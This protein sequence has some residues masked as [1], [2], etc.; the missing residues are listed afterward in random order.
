MDFYVKSGKTQL[1]PYSV[2]TLKERGYW[3]PE[4]LV[5]KENG[6]EWVRMADLTPADLCENVKKEVDASKNP[7]E[8]PESFTRAEFYVL[9]TIFP[10]L[11]IA[12]FCRKRAIDYYRGENYELF[13]K[14]EEKVHTCIVVAI[15]LICFLVVGLAFYSKTRRL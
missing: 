6:T 11:I 9:A 13:Q 3:K 14:Y 10:L 15:G 8:P 1:G 4:I 2:E 5:R 12:I 7:P